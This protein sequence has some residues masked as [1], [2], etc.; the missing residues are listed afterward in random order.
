MLKN[1]N[2][3]EGQKTNILEKKYTKKALIKSNVYKD[4]RDLLNTL[5]EN[6]KTYTKSEIDK[7]IDNY[8]KRRVK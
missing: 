8:L 3:A 7:L 2:K 6:N 1:E 4:N 5:L